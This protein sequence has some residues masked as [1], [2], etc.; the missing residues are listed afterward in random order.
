M[1]DEAKILYMTVEEYLEAEERATIRHEYVDGQVFAMSGATD[2]HNLIAGNL[3]ALMHG[4]LRGSGCR[5]YIN[6]M[7]VQIQSRKSFYYPDI[8][9]TCEPFSA[10]SV[11]K[12]APT[13]LIEVL[14]PSTRQIDRREKLVAYKQIDTLKEYLVVYQD[15]RR[16]EVYRRDRNGHWELTVASGKEE[17]L[18]QSL[19]TGPLA[20]SLDIIYDGFDLPTIVGESGFSYDV[21]AEYAEM[22]EAW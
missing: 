14:S 21:D 16:V 5:A 15:R 8:M 1:P 2:A 4:H 3:Y 12:D 20:L 6:D 10:K 19:P 7:K 13:L 22:Q 18:L 11:F 9:V 17:L